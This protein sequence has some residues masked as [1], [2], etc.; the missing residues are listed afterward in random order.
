MDVAGAFLYHFRGP[1]VFWCFQKV[2]KVKSGMKRLTGRHNHYVKSVRFGAIPYLAEIFRISPYSVQMP[3][4]ADQNNSEYGHFLR[5]E[6]FL[7]DCRVA[8]KNSKA[9]VHWMF[10]KLVVLKN[11]TKFT[12]KDLCRSLFFNKVAGLKKRQTPGRV[13][14]WRFFKNFKNTYFMKH[15]RASFSEN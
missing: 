3:E 7:K 2:K 1:L 15:L 6:Y 12:R 5:I 4:N 13:L 8:W 9:A 10:Y 14:S 11:F